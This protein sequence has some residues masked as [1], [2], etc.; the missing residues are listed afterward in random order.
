[1]ADDD[2]TVAN[3]PPPSTGERF[4]AGQQSTLSDELADAVKIVAHDLGWVVTTS[5]GYKRVVVRSSIRE[6]KEP[7]S[8]LRDPPATATTSERRRRH[9]E[10][11]LWLSAVVKLVEEA[12]PLPAKVPAA[13]EV[14]WFWPDNGDAPVRVRALGPYLSRGEQLWHCWMPGRWLTNRAPELKPRVVEAVKLT[15]LGPLDPAD[16]LGRDPH[17]W[18][19][20]TGEW[21]AGCECHRDSYRPPSEQV[22]FDDEEDDDDDYYDD[23]Y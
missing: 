22:T 16:P 13:S 2:A 12:H 5:T 21:M 18:C 6:G 4:R 19:P 8:V 7:T 15:Q 14:V 20:Q 23:D 17:G 9:A 3:Q 11:R 10:Q 1:M